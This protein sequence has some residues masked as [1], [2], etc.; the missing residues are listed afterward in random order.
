MPELEP[1][2][3]LQWFKPKVGNKTA[4]LVPIGPA[5][6]PSGWC[7]PPLQPIRKN[8]GPVS[9]YEAEGVDAEVVV[10]SGK[11]LAVSFAQAPDYLWVTTFLAKC[12]FD[13]FETFIDRLR[14]AR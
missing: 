4:R 7:D 6:T 14:M 9:S 12:A 2:P 8:G 11:L 5:I 1:R 10:E 3:E 13:G